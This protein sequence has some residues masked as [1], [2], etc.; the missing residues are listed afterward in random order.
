MKHWKEQ[1]RG[2]PAPDSIGWLGLIVILAVAFAVAG[3]AAGWLAG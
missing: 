1:G 3:L 2:E